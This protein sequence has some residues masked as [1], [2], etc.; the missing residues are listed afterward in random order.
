MLHIAQ[1][2]IALVEQPISS[3]LKLHDRMRSLIERGVLSTTT[4]WMGCFG[5]ESAKGTWLCS[6][7]QD[8][9][10]ALTRKLKRGEHRFANDH[11]YEPHYSGGVT[12]GKNLKQTQEYTAEYCQAVFNAVDSADFNALVLDIQS[13]GVPQCVDLWLDAGMQELAAY[14]GVP[15]HELVF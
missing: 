15:L 14:V 13:P 8:V 3:I 5:A 1:G 4:T 12:G 6:N 10:T 9:L 2:V 11:I 7:S